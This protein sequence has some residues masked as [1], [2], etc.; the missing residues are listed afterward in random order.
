MNNKT[1]RL[2]AFI[3]NIVSIA[4]TGIVAL[5]GLVYLASVVSNGGMAM[6]AVDLYEAKGKVLW[7]A[8]LAWMIP[9]TVHS[10]GIY[11]GKRRNTVAFG[12]CTLIFVNVVSGILLLCSKKDAKA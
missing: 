2:A 7:F 8:C 10:W 5:S 4:L 11:K 1:L 6:S 3:F 12:V 9:M